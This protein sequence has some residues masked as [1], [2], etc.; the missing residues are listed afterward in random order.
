LQIGAGRQLPSRCGLG[1]R[2]PVLLL[3]AA[4]PGGGAS[5]GAASRRRW[6][7]AGGLVAGGRPTSPCC[8]ALVRADRRS[9]GAF[10]SVGHRGVQGVGW[11][12]AVSHPPK[13]TGEPVSRPIRSGRR[14]YAADTH[15]ERIPHVSV[16]DTYPTRIRVP[17]T[18]RGNRVLLHP[19]SLGLYRLQVEGPSFKGSSTLPICEIS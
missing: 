2:P 15:P 6:L 12:W 11:I 7:V 14:R 8:V 18:Y 5:R 9:G 10:Y 19:L 17:C 1:R 4:S 16:S 13:R 3:V